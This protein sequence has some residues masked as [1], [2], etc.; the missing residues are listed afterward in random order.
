MNALEAGG[1]V[2]P[3]PAPL[4][5]ARAEAERRSA[6]R[7]LLARPLLLAE[8]DPEAYAAVVRHRAEL[9]RWFQENAGWTLVVDPAGRHARLMKR[10]ARPD[11][12]R[13]ARAPGK[14]AFDRRRYVLLALALAALDDEPVQVTLARLAEKVRDLSLEE[15][16]LA[17][18]DPEGAPERHAFVDVVRLL[19]DLGVL[20][21][22]DGDVERYARSREGDALY[23]VRERLLGRL[24]AAPRPPA[25]AASPAHMAEE[26]RAGTEEGER[27]AG[28]H[29]VFRRLLDDPVVYKEDLDARGR[30]WL[31]AGSGFLYERLA[32]DAGLAVERRAEGLL[33]VD[34]DGSLTD[35]VFPE[36]GSTVKHAALLLCEWLA[37]RG[38][39]ARRAMGTSATSATT[40]TAVVT[41][42]VHA[43]R[44]R[45][46]APAESRDARW[47]EVV[48][49]VR[50]LQDAHAGRWSKEFDA[51]DAGAGELAR[52]AARL[53]VAFGLAAFTDGGALAARPAA[54]RFAP[55]DAA[56][57]RSAP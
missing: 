3:G 29:A 54:A 39:E 40:S 26:E 28:R 52:E 35:V 41:D 42:P 57:E 37:D 47:P 46:E 51:T 7:A 43:E 53:L 6:L 11:P 17:P 30:D 32:R 44:S 21:L 24:L 8:R 55:R 16:E 36:G 13:P 48:A 31:A 10:P 45:R 2:A 25:L 18:F 23:D 14:R 19:E 27:T 56:P 50:A 1:T 9:V 20:A 15:P 4:H 33:A 34:R 5:E 49:R 22:R 12:T 38:R